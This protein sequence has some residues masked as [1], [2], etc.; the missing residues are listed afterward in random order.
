MRGRWDI[1]CFWARRLIDRHFD[2]LLLAGLIA[3]SISV[4]VVFRVLLLLGRSSGLDQPGNEW[5]REQTALLIGGLL[6]LLRGEHHRPHHD[7][8]TNF[9]ARDDLDSGKGR[10]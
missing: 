8:A 4:S 3:T 10:Q 7:D 1:F 6:G 9:A 5:L 2:K